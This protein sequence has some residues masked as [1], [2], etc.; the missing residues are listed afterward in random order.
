MLMK[1]QKKKHQIIHKWTVKLSLSKIMLLIHKRE[2]K[3]SLMLSKSPKIKRQQNW[4]KLDG[5]ATLYK[6][7]D[8]QLP[9]LVLSIILSVD[10]DSLITCRR[11]LLR[12]WEVDSL[13]SKKLKLTWWGK[14]TI[15]KLYTNWTT[16]GVLWR[17]LKVIRVVTIS[18]LVI[19][20]FA[21]APAIKR[22]L[23][24]GL[25]GLTMLCKIK[26][27]LSDAPSFCFTE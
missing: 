24:D 15:V 21:Q 10:K 2:T 17:T 16:N 8:N 19:G 25:N 27:D 6:L 9:D 26:I 4:K 13:L 22:N 18:K 1:Y 12:I 14:K 23:T 11:G 7:S 3:S 20:I 5:M